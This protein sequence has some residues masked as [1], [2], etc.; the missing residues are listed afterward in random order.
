[1]LYTDT[2]GRLKQNDKYN[3]IFVKC[4][5]LITPKIRENLGAFL[6]ICVLAKI[7]DLAQ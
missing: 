7:G 6:R 3:H 1:M 2:V 4:Q 5:G